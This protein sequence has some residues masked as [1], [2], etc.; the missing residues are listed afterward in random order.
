MNDF[1]RLSLTVNGIRTNQA[2]KLATI[3]KVNLEAYLAVEEIPGHLANY[4][5]EKS[6]KQDMKWRAKELI[7]CN[8]IK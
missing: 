2:S 3:F 5:L 7:R 4:Y 1:S 8:P 6:F